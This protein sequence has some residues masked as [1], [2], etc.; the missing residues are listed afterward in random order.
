[1]LLQ[2]DP[3][4]T[5][6]KEICMRK[7]QPYVP[8]KAPVQDEDYQMEAASRLEVGQRCEVDPGAKRGEIK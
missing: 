3:E 7:G 6:E 8:P 2:E 1:M 5:A 4:W